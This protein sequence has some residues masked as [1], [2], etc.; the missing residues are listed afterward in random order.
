MSTD[1]SRR[2]G[3]EEEGRLNKDN[4][5]DPAPVEFEVLTSYL[6]VCPASLGSVE[7]LGWA[8][9]SEHVI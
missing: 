5:L 8:H 6:S 4:D 7:R 9:L 3:F 2:E 1:A